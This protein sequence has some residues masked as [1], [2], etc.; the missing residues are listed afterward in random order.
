MLTV[1]VLGIVRKTLEWFRRNATIQ[2]VFLTILRSEYRT[3]RKNRTTR[4][5][6]IS[7]NNT[8]SSHETVITYFDRPKLLLTKSNINLMRENLRPHP[9]NCRELSDGYAAGTV[10]MV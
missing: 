6:G 9:C 3:C 1:E 8:T 10:D 5:G 2:R 7:Q 4:E